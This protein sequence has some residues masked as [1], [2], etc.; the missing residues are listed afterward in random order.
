MMR[1]LL[2]D[3]EK[4]MRRQFAEECGGIADIHL[5]GQF[6]SS[7]DALA[8]AEE[9]RVDLAFLD[10][11]MPGMNGLELA[12]RLRSIYPEVI[13]IFVSAYDKY[14][15]EAFKI[16]AD[17]F[18]M[19]P[20]TRE[21]ILSVLE[22]ARLLSRRL[23]KK[24]YIRTFGNFDVFVDDKP[25]TFTSAKAKE[26]LA[27]LVD[28]RGGVL[29]AEEAFYVMW[30]NKAY[31]NTQAAAYRRAL[32][33]LKDTLKK[34]GVEDI[35]L[36]LPHGKAI[37]LDA[38]NC[39]YFQFLDGSISA[40]R[41]FGG[42]YMSDYSWGEY[43][44]AD[45]EKKA[46]LLEANK[47]GLSNNDI[48]CACI[49]CQNDAALTLTYMNEGFLAI[50]GYSREAI[51]EKFKNSLRALVVEEDVEP[52]FA[53]ITDQMRRGCV[54]ELEFRLNTSSG[55]PIWVMDRGELVDKGDGSKEFVCIMVD[56][57]ARKA[58]M[59]AVKQKAERDMLTGLY[60]SATAKYMIDA[61]LKNNS[62]EKGSA[63]ILLDIDDFKKINDALG[64]PFGDAVLVAAAHALKCAFRS[65]DLV[66]RIGG[67]EMM[68]FAKDIPTKEFIMDK[69]NKIL[70]DMVRES[71]ARKKGLELTCSIGVAYYPDDGDSFDSLYRKADVALC[72]SKA[73]GKRRATFY[74]GCME[75]GVGAGRIEPETAIE[76]DMNSFAGGQ[77]LEYAFSQ[78]ADT[79]DLFASINAL[80]AIVG[81]QLDTSRVYIFE[82]ADDEDYIVNTF[83]WCESG[84]TPQIDNLQKLSKSQLQRYYDNLRISDGLFYCRD[85]RKL[86]SGLRGILEP[87]GIKSML[88]CALDDHGEYF[89]FM[90]F[91][92]CRKIR[93]WS[94]QQ[95]KALSDLSKVVA[96]FLRK[97]RLKHGSAF[98]DLQNRQYKG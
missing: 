2:V 92:E 42:E 23:R 68:I 63:M 44:V 66:A 79:D 70:Q 18:L 32:R 46:A 74:D 48:P 91:D 11:E 20:C 84:V 19:K 41:L 31:D 86:E 98:K 28:R 13:V 82:N 1:T 75:N 8:F 88:H 71:L 87:Q 30:E 49:R 58:S 36:D 54:K 76:S 77:F 39:D 62:D 67:D 16:Q 57:S 69:L 80:L 85:A 60:N 14:M 9:N 45:L 59:M 94:G 73:D 33:K 72:K 12:K 53:E 51:A 40:M 7:E 47:S 55:D 38:V 27:L 35:L 24:V 43:I 56:I 81:R 25:M 64:H 89:G 15:A 93:Y 6:D 3:D 22:R 34:Y 95:V 10:I 83:E 97:Y 26:L 90:G 78:M 29:D 21:D 37:N 17:Y 96:L 61:Y 65:S 5:V 50:T 4:W 52:M